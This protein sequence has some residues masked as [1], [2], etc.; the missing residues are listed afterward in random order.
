MNALNAS[1]SPILELAAARE[2]RSRRRSILLTLIP[3]LFGVALLW[4][5]ATLAQRMNTELLGKQEQ[6]AALQ[7]QLKSTQHKL[8]DARQDLREGRRQLAAA[9]SGLESGQAQLAALQLQADLSQQRLAELQ[10]KYDLLQQ[11]Y[12]TLQMTLQRLT[13]TP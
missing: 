1:T 9:Q 13:P 6:L 12:Q 11:D 4:Q 10:E 2:R 7:S 8:D 5:V 3:L